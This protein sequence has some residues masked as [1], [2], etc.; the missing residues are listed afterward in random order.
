MQYVWLENVIEK[1][2]DVTFQAYVIDWNDSLDFLYNYVNDK[3]LKFFL[4]NH[5][6]KINIFKE[7]IDNISSSEASIFWNELEKEFHI[8]MEKNQRVNFKVLYNN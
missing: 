7:N 8:E 2:N 1:Y 5:I 4:K 6:Y 3:K